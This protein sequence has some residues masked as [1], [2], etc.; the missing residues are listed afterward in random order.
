MPASRYGTPRSQEAWRSARSVLEE[1]LRWEVERLSTSG[2][3][4][5]YHEL[6]FGLGLGHR[7]DPASLPVPVALPLGEQE[8]E[9]AGSID[10]VDILSSRKDGRVQGLAVDY[11]TGNV[12]EFRKAL[13]SGQEIQLPLY[14]R[15][16]ERGFGVEPVGAL[17]LSVRYRD[18]AGFV[19]AEFA[20]AMGPLSRNVLVLEEGDWKAL[21]A[22]A[23]EEM[24]R[25]HRAMMEP[26][27][28][29]RPRGWDCGFCQL[30]GLCRIDLWRAKLNA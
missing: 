26:R 14:L 11:K 22:R 1:F 29:A 28:S 7:H 21:R 9:F 25:L 2:L 19:R 10:R 30:G 12:R 18:M 27:I 3:H 5:R 15:I 24:E 4:P 23:D 8:V 20:H 13:E 16:L 6:A 17:Y